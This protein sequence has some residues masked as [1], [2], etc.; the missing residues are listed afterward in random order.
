MDK[1]LI[2]EHIFL[3]P[4]SWSYNHKKDTNLFVQHTQI[5][6]KFF[7]QLEGWEEHDLKLVTEK[8][9]NEFVYFYKP[10]RTALYTIHKEPVIVRNYTY[11]SLASNN[12]FIITVSGIAYKLHIEAIGLKIY[13]TGIG[14]LSFTLSNT[15]YG[16]FE[17]IEGINSFSKGVYPPLLP[18]SKAKEEL[19]PDEIILHLND[20]CHIDE[21][22]EKNYLKKGLDISKV[23]MEVL[24][25][26]FEPKESHGKNGKIAIETILGNQM[27]CLCLY[28]NKEILR[29]IQEGTVS[30]ETLERMMTINKKVAYHEEDDI[31]EHI[32]S[33][34]YLKNEGGIYGISRFALLCVAKEIPKNRLYDQLVSLVLMQRATLLSLSNEIAKVSTLGKEEISSAISSIYEIYIQFINQ[35]YFKEVT[36]DAQ[37]AHIYEKLSEQL[38]IQE[39]LEQLN[40]EIDEVR[41]YANLVEQAQSTVKVE[42]LTI[43]GAALVIPSFVTSL[44]GMN[45]LQKEINHWWRSERVGLWMNS[46][47]LLP[48]LVTVVVCTWNKKKTKLHI[49]LKIIY[50]LIFCCSIFIICRYGSGV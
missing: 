11:K 37:G 6:K 25:K 38:K 24:G 32:G 39:E 41:E 34:Y 40:F 44:F 12:Y 45:I 7:T 1:E 33:T 46:Y 18:L 31:P 8:D 27:F 26:D 49:T 30:Y 16:G 17:A 42:L 21:R 35:L 2:S 50:V 29:S 4:F 28:K 5:Q 48:V 43:I 23:I 19:F 15:D 20:Q 22:Y 10:I 36:E 13:K 3:F 9:Y 14:L 47:V